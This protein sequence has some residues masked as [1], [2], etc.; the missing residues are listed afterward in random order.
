MQF[1]EAVGVYFIEPRH[2]LVP[3]LL[4]FGKIK[5]HPDASASASATSISAATSDID[6]ESIMTR[7]M[8]QH[9]MN[10]RGT[11]HDLLGHAPHVDARPPEPVDGALDA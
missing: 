11:E 7:I 3:V 9:V 2:V 5:F 1:T 4:Q 6:V 10:V 8:T